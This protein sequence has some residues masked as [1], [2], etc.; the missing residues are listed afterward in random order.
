MQFC[1]RYRSTSVFS[2]FSFFI[3]F[4]SFLVLGCVRFQDIIAEVSVNCVRHYTSL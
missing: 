3:F 1:I 2:F 4:G